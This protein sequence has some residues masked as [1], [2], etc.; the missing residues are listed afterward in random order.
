MKKTRT[1]GIFALLIIALL[2]ADGLGAAAAVKGHTSF[3]ARVRGLVAGLVPVL[4]ASAAGHATPVRA[5]AE[6]VIV[7]PAE[8]RTPYLNLSVA[9][10]AA[11]TVYGAGTGLRELAGGSQAHA[12]ASAD[13]DEDGTPDLVGAY[14]TAGGGVVTIQRG[15]VDALFPNSPE[16]RGRR[17][18]GR[19]NDAPF[20][21]EAAAFIVPEAAHFVGAGDFDADGHYDVAAARR[22]GRALF[23]LRGD[24]RG[25]LLAP[26]RVELPGA[27]TAFATGEVNRPDGLADIVVGVSGVEGATALVFES[28]AGALRG[29]PETLSLPAAASGL[30]LGALDADSSADLAVASG[31]ELLIVHGRDRLLSLDESLR[32]DVPEAKVSRSELEFALAGV[33]VGDFAGDE[34]ADVAVLSTDGVVQVLTRAGGDDKTATKPDGEKS[35]D[36][37]AAQGVEAAGRVE[38]QKSE[39]ASVRVAEGVSEASG[40]LGLLM[41]AKVSSLSKDD[42]LVL[43]GGRVHVVTNEAAKTVERKVR[44]KASSS[45]AATELRVSASVGT[46]S[47]LAAV[48]PMRLSVSALSGLVVAGADSKAPSVLSQAAPVTFTVNSTAD[49]GDANTSNGEC[50]DANGNCTL[51]AALDE[52]VANNSNQNA[53]PYTIN[54]NIPGAG[55][56][57]ISTTG[58]FALHFNKKPVVIDGT[59]QAAG[60]VEIID[61]AGIDGLLR[62]D[63]GNSTIRGLV[64]SG[65][66]SGSISLASN[67]NIIEGCYFSTNADGTAVATRRNFINLDVRSSNNRIGGTTAAARNVISGATDKGILIFSGSGNLIQGNYVGTNAAG[68]AAI[69]N[70]VAG[71]RI[72]S[73]GNTVGGTTAGAGNL[74]SGNENGGGEAALSFVSSNSHG[75]VQGNLFG[76]D[77]SGNSRLANAGDALNV[78]FSDPG[79]GVTMT[80]GGTTPA[81]RNIISGS[82]GHGIVVRT[83]LNDNS[84]YVQGNYIGTNADGTVAIPNLGHGVLLNAG[85]HIVGGAVSGAGNLISGNG[86]DGIFLGSPGHTI[87][88]NLIGTDVSGTLALPNSGDGIE[89]SRADRTLIG[90]TTP[91]ARNVISGNRENGLRFGPVDNPANNPVRVEGNYIG[92]N[93]FGT[94]PLGNGSHGIN[95][96]TTAGNNVGG[97]SPGAGNVIAHNGESGIASENSIIGGAVLSNSIYSNAELGIDIGDNGV[98]SDAVFPSARRPT[99]TSVTNTGAGTVI[100][101]TIP[102]HNSFTPYTIQFFS[103][104]ACDPSGHGEGQTFI[105]QTAFTP[106]T[107]NVPVNFSH[108]VSP[109]VPGGTFI[110]AVA[111]RQD[112]GNNIPGAFYTSEFSNCSQLAAPTPTPTPT[113]TPTPTPTPT[114]VPLQLF[115]IAPARGGDTAV[116]TRQLTGQGFQPGATARLTRAGQSDIVGTDVSITNDGTT[117]TATFD[118][119][120]KARGLWSVVVTNPGGATAMLPDAFNIGE[121]RPAKVWV[122]IIGRFKMRL[123]RT[124]TFYLAYGNTGDVDAEPTMFHVLIPP[125]LN[126]VGLPRLANGGAPVVLRQG[127]S[128]GLEFYVPSI[129]ATSSTYLPLELN[130]DDMLAHTNVRIQSLAFSSPGLREAIEAPSDP[131]STVTVETLVKTAEEEKYVFH[132]NGPNG[133]YDVGVEASVTPDTQVREPFF[134]RVKVG[135]EVHYRYAVS[136]ASSQ[137]PS[138][139][140]ASKAAPGEMRTPGAENTLRLSKTVKV[141]EVRERDYMRLTLEGRRYVHEN[142]STWT[143]NRKQLL[144]CLR[145]Q[146]LLPRPDPDYIH[147][148][149]LDKMADGVTTFLVTEAII[150]DVND[151]KTDHTF[152]ATSFLNHPSLTVGS[153]DYM[154]VDALGPN[155]LGPEAAAIH[156]DFRTSKAETN[157]QAMM[158][159]LLLS[160]AKCLCLNN[161]KSQNRAVAQDAHPVVE[162]ATCPTCPRVESCTTCQG[163]DKLVVDTDLNIVF[164]SDPNEKF[165]PQ[166][167]EAAH[168]INGATPSSYVVFFENKPEATA[169][170]QDVIVTDQLDL[171]KFDLSTFQLGPV[172]FGKDTFVTPPPGLSQWMTDVDLRPANNLIVRVNAGLNP[173]TGIVRWS[174]ISLDPATMQPTDDP[175]AG[176]LPPNK[177]APE[178]EGSVL[179]SV[180]PKPEVAT[181]DEVRNGARIVF[182]VNAP[183]D[184]PVWLNTVDKS[185][186]ASAVKQLSTTQPY[187]VF[188][189]DW[190]G[191]DTGSGL[192]DYTVFFSEDGGPYAAWL[193]ETTETS[194]IFAGKPGKTYSFYSVARDRAGNVEA[195]K[196]SPE[197]TTATPNVVVNPIDDARF[198]VLQHYRDFLGRDP[199]PAGFD[200]WTNEIA[201]CG[202]D[203]G[204]IDVKRTNVSQAFFL[205]IE[206][207]QTGFLVHRFYR[208]TFAASAQRPGGLPRMD[209]LLADARAVGAGVVVGEAGWELKLAQNKQAFA[210]EWVERP[211]V[212]AELPAGMTAAQFVD[213]LFATSSV[214][215]TAPERDAALAAFGAGGVEGRAAAL[216]TVTESGSVFNRQYNPAFVLMQ[217][218]GYLR[219]NPNDAP[220]SD[221]TGFDFWLA[222]MNSFSAPG[223]DIRDPQTAQRRVQR[224][225]MVRAF[226]VSDE[227]R[228]RF[229]Q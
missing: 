127:H 130:T 8:G 3:A 94:G 25:N 146:R 212:L 67:N 208:A 97:T 100:T 82:N 90:G 186:P 98:S 21:A 142:V 84:I 196:T 118:L 201:A 120:G 43:G 136:L 70:R 174:F 91:E 68:T 88:G 96:K 27:L 61:T 37:Q 16:A 229:G 29:Q 188:N 164:S 51:R 23:L 34:R 185:L 153:F 44:G 215:P 178:G 86:E 218:V 17:E 179:F 59:T 204:C 55:V 35:G 83:F 41:K 87:Q 131:P 49:T 221:Y 210:R 46:E 187:V 156:K 122:D 165:G 170:A 158:K 114:P 184:T 224:A 76:T 108:T 176:F 226:I 216:C 57:T 198:F 126:V 53:G 134:E 14:A 40:A 30:A 117:L 138:L 47:E 180:S 54:F 32:N 225:E 73:A 56:P 112:D 75:L 193:S 172:S 148:S 102:N 220:D 203:A 93:R 104:P 111:V 160:L 124:Q 52:I 181:G 5:T 92:L 205:S 219:R 58:N 129:A 28:P 26:E 66:G 223:E 113:G 199:D 62:I 20:H 182:D 132:V 39:A 6:R 72:F 50:K 77:A 168:F 121:P 128:T 217:Y 64:M 177:T 133:N 190:A 207:Q 222:K 227:Y 19:F 157:D 36:A 209:E 106:T 78:F 4:S 1:A 147:T 162:A 2:V 31:T 135:D 161:N 65:S 213:K 169:P 163:C 195:A 144:E 9:A 7:Q 42:L 159:I 125:G 191:T 149:H 200:F 155:A 63:G 116:V 152:T 175:T 45:E 151:K 173:Q 69:G 145:L 189:V 10:A 71:I 15:N 85:G 105:G 214:T 11:P 150:R 154:L 101:G 48:L 211:E 119:A 81:A 18:Q 197:A 24:G 202:G 137:L 74:I 79:A 89:T 171:T 183:I 194:A 167:V 192:R 140:P 80:I 103:N 110:T 141:T 166:G 33:A 60:R 139:R 143:V 22:G 38:W 123:G 99:L 95:F 115:V 109:A 12:L 228:K 13:F 206:F 107:Q